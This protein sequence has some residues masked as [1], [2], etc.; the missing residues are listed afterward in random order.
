M[1][2]GC[3]RR[4]INNKGGMFF[5]RANKLRHE[6]MVINDSDVRVE[7]NYLR[8][9]VAP[10]RNPKVRGVT[11][12]YVSLEDRTF[13]QHLQSIGMFCDFFPGVFVARQLDGIKFAFGPTIVTTRSCLK[14][15]GC[16]EAL[17]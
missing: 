15:F 8:T 13:T 14:G 9:V 10:L 17:G 11:C 5:R 2:V 3:G 7:P 1:L 12:L 16:Y 6:V 4:A